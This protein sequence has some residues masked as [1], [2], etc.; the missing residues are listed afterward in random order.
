MDI[1][2]AISHPIR[3]PSDDFIR[4]TTHKTQALSDTKIAEL[5]ETPDFAISHYTDNTFTQKLDPVSQ[6]SVHEFRSEV[7][8]IYEKARKCIG[9]K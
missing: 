9:E 4:A 3:K 5:L 6:M 7:N 2:D 1:F 8:K